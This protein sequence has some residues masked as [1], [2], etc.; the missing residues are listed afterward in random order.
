MVGVTQM[1]ALDDD[2]DGECAAAAACAAFDADGSMYSLAEGAIAAPGCTLG[3]V[4]RGGGGSERQQNAAAGV[5]EF[6]GEA[7]QGC[8]SRLHNEEQSTARPTPMRRQQHHHLQ[9]DK[10]IAA[11]AFVAATTFAPPQ[12]LTCARGVRVVD[13]PPSCP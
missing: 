5:V 12:R 13:C 1:G 3:V 4:A 11:A 6:A 10:I 9:F 2:D 8:E 7:K